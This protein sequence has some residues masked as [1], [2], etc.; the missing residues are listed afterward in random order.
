MA[1]IISK[2]DRG[3]QSKSVQNSHPLKG[4]RV[5]VVD[6][7]PH[8]RKKL[9]ELYVSLGFVFAG[10]ASDGLECLEMAERLQPDLISLDIIMPVM[11]GVETLGYLKESGN[12]GIV[13]FVTALQNIEEF[14][15][16]KFVELRGHQAE[17]VFSKKDSRE[18]FSDVLSQIF[19]H[20]EEAQLMKE[21]LEEGI[22]S[23]G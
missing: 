12:K 13:V 19:G 1:T 18:T 17:A 6:D 16:L 2:Y 4:K 10:E 5:L 7:N 22:S 21:H 8:Q 9:K 3:E 20:I 15:E 23:V 11:H 14:V